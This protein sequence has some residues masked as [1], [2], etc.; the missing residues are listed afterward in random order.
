MTH[1]RGSQESLEDFFPCILT[2]HPGHTALPKISQNFPPSNIFPP[3]APGLQGTKEFWE[4][5]GDAIHGFSR[6]SHIPVPAA[7]QGRLANSNT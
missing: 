6:H 3:K 4:L 2:L 1:F 7:L 5:F